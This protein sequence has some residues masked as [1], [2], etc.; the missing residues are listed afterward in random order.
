MEPTGKKHVGRLKHDKDGWVFQGDQGK[1]IPLD[2]LSYIRFEAKATPLP[3]APLANALLLPN[4]QR[5]M[6][7]LVSL[8]EKKVVFTA[9]W[10]KS[11]TLDREQI[12]GI[13]QTELPIAH[14]DFEMSLKAWRVEGKPT[15][16]KERAF[17]GRSSL[18][19][20]A[21]GQS[22]MC[23]W[24]SASPDLTIRLFFYDPAIASRSPLG[25]SQ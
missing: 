20:D 9:G 14:D 15:L 16:S 22:V 18:L 11:L 12:T 8:D 5:I 25:V 7:T 6:G 10:G 4:G 2:R 13:E 17:F 24:Q 1:P 19:L 23:D 21:A 3:K